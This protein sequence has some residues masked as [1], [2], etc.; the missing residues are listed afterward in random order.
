MET[1]KRFVGMGRKQMIRIFLWDRFEESGKQ[2]MCVWRSR[3]I[4]KPG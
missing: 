2:K 3:R 4:E 1:G